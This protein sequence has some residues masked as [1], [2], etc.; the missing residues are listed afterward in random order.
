M[1]KRGNGRGKAMRERIALEAARIM[2]EQGLRDFA[3]AKRKAA[4]RLG[5]A[6]TQHMPKNLEI[7]R[8]LV[9]YQRLFQGNSHP[10]A[11]K[12][13]REL[14]LQAMQFFS[15]FEPRLVGEVLTGTAGMYSDLHLHVFSD[16]PEALALFLTDHRIPHE[17]GEKRLRLNREQVQNY[18]VYRFVADDIRVE[19]TVFPLAGMRHPPLSPV[20]GKPMRRAPLEAVRKLLEG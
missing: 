2:A 15:R 6:D 20:D 13:R 7:E 14:A 11:L 1:D 19:L 4:L 9:E 17:Q 16:A 8:A 3:L 18:S 5:A 12:K 10:P